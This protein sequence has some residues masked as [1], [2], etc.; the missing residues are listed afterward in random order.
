MG[1]AVCSVGV[2]RQLSWMFGPFVVKHTL[3][4][5]SAAN[6]WS[7]VLL[8]HL[9]SR[10]RQLCRKETTCSEG[11]C[12]EYDGY[13]LGDA[14]EWLEDAD[15]QDRRQLTEGV[16]EAKRCAPEQAEREKH[17]HSEALRTDVST[18]SY[19]YNI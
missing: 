6:C 1:M 7:F 3:Q 17:D 12:S 18:K 16:Q 9:A 4:L 2:W 14:D 8:Q 10:F 15:A 13:G 5:C 19:M 11:A